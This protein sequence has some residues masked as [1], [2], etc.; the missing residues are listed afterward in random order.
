MVTNIKENHYDNQISS[1]KFPNM[2]R[3]NDVRP[4]EGRCC[5]H[6]IVS[7]VVNWCIKTSLTWCNENAIALEGCKHQTQKFRG[8]NKWR[9]VTQWGTVSKGSFYWVLKLIQDCFGFAEKSRQP[10]EKSSAKLKAIAAW[11]FTFLR[12][13]LTLNTYW[14]WA[15]QIECQK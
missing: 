1:I 10:L 9:C 15:I 7:A 13:F 8:C 12:A 3:D 11:W 4:L 2:K 6:E 14:L 5:H